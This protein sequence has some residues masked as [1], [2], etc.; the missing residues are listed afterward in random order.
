M[1]TIIACDVYKLCL[2]R[3]NFLKVYF[4]IHRNVNDKYLLRQYVHPSLS[5]NP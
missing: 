3:R 4:R 1:C 2:E 5:E